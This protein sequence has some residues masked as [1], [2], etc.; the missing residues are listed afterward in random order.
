MEAPVKI[1]LL[2]DLI[3]WHNKRIDRG[4]NLCRSNVLESF[5]VG[6]PRHFSSRLQLCWVANLLGSLT[7]CFTR[8]FLALSHCCGRLQ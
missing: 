4:G 8:S 2:L 3:R 1:A 6:G 5:V 7:L